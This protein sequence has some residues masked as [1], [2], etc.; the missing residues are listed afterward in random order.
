VE[1]VDNTL[2]I[3]V[4]SEHGALRLV[5]ILTFIIVWIAGF[6][7]VSLLI[8]NN[9]L[10][11]L[12]ILIGFG[13]AYGITTLVER[14]LKQRWPSGRA[15]QVD[16]NGVK[17]LHKG[18][19]QREMMSEDPVNTL[20][21]TFKIA[22]R[23]RVPKGWSMLGCAL[24]YENVYLTV[25]TFMPPTQVETLDMAQ[26]FKKLISQRKGQGQAEMREDLRVAGEQRRLRDA[27][28][29]RW[30]EGAEMTPSDFIAYVN[31]IKAQ[32]PEWMPLN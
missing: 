12:A 11:L 28:T 4:D 14:F 6:V 13:A 22:K 15:V 8:P 5:V 18:A 7:V 19:L 31:R 10:S 21:W 26:Q 25:Y 20:L 2:T 1:T 17:L 24:E 23:A 32:F 29:N 27:E 3:S 30:M 16:R 9:G